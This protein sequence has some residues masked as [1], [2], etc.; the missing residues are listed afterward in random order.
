VIGDGGKDGRGGS[1]RGSSG[2]SRGGGGRGTDGNGGADESSWGSRRGP[3][4]PAAPGG[5]RGPDRPRSQGGTRSAV[6]G[7]RGPGRGAGTGS[8]ATGTGRASPAGSGTERGGGTG[9]G[10]AARRS[11]A[12]NGAGAP[13]SDRARSTRAGTGQVPAGRV[14]G[15]R[16]PAGRGR[17]VGRGAAGRPGA[18]PGAARRPA[19]DGPFR[20][21]ARARWVL[22][23]KNPKHRL[24]ATALVIAVVLSLFAGRLVQMQGLDWVRYRTQAERQRTSYITIPTL[25]GSI[26]TSDGTVL[27]MTEQTAQVIAD[28]LQITTAQRPLVAQALAAPLATPAA[29]LLDDLSHPTSPGNVVLKKSVSAAV[30]R[31]INGLRLAGYSYDGLPG[32]VTKATYARSYPNGSLAANLVGFTSTNPANGDITGKAGLESQFN[33]LLAGKDGSEEVE[34]GTNGVPIPLTQAAIKSP[35][36]ARSLRLTINSSIEFDAE[37]QCKA[38]VKLAKARN[39]SVVVMVPHTGKILAIA[40]YPTFNPSHITNIADTGD[41]AATNIFAPGSTLKPLTVAADLEKGGQKPLNTYVVPDHISVNGLPYHDAEVHPT[42]RYT[43]AGILANSLNDGMVQ[44]VQHITPLQQ[45]DYLRAFGLGSTTG[46]GLAGE[47]AGIVLKPGASNYYGDEP[48]EM[49]FG[50][51]IEVTA[52]QMASVY[53]TLGNG[54]MRVQPSLVAGTTSSSGKFTPAPAPKQRRVIQAKTDRELMTM[55][56]QVPKVD[57]RGDEPWGL[58]AGYPVAS[59]TGTAQV[60]DTGKCALCQYGS[61]YIGISPAQSPKLV[62]AV[63]VQDPT[64]NGYYGDEIAGPVFYHVMKFALQSLKIPPTNAKVPDIRLTKR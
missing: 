27:A 32:I 24:N 5:R 60:S 7:L 18:P 9:P 16:A 2:G 1:G 20:P 12:A 42:Q 47:S 59:K 15:G 57:E 63:N 34:T 28:P 10:G 23:R 31:Q 64:A 19:Q 3:R 62:V 58:I 43:I 41:I 22:R 45:Y 37:Q 46:L 38:E 44:I 11:A 25:R 56:E 8:A 61:S 39:C 29:T 30:A 33:S 52:L 40:Q 51:G 48:E 50:Q 14:P 53:A 21:R 17:A 35:V 49:S 6:T 54:G 4:P 13:G 55:M 26:T 36:P